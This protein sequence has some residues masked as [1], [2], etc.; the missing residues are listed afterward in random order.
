MR[1]SDGFHK[2]GGVAEGLFEVGVIADYIQPRPYWQNSATQVY[3][4]YA[5]W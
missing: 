1:P 2:G 4:N 5:T 3:W